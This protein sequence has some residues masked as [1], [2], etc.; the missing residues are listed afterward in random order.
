MR[1]ARTSRESLD[2]VLVN[3]SRP[4]RLV[5]EAGRQLGGPLGF[6]AAVANP[7]VIIVGGNLAE[8]PEPLLAGIRET[9]YG[10]YP[11]SL[12]STIDIV[13]SSLGAEAGLSG[14][15][16]LALDTVLLPENVDATLA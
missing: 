5:R 3:H 7:A 4:L 1:R 14:A 13:A 10:S 9:I 6:L 2:L 15:A 12:T 8:S 16:R 11:P